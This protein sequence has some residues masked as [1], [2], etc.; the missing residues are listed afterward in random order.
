MADAFLLGAGFSKALHNVMPS[1]N[2]LYDLLEVLVNI[3]QGIPEVE[4]EF[5]TGS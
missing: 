3:P 1:M 4:P 2:E 5:R